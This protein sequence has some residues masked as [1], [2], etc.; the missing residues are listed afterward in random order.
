MKLKEAVERVNAQ[1][2]EAKSVLSEQGTRVHG[3]DHNDPAYLKQ[4]AW[5]NDLIE[6]VSH[7]KRLHVLKEAMTTDDFP[8]LFGDTIDRTLLAKYQAWLP[9]WRAWCRVGDVKDFRV[10]KRYAVSGGQDIL[11]QV[12]ERGPYN[13]RHIDE[14]AALSIHVDKY[15]GTFGLSWEAFLNDDLGALKDLPDRLS[16]GAR[17]TESLLVTNLYVDTNGPHASLYTGGNNNCIPGNPALSVS[18]LAAGIQCFADMVDADGHPI[19]IDGYTL[20]VP[21]ALEVTANNIANALQIEMEDTGGSATQKLIAK[22]WLAGRY[23]VEVDPYI[24]YVAAAHQ[25]TMWFLFAK[26]VGNR[27]A[28]EVAYLA[29]ESVPALFMKA[30]DQV[31]VGGGGSAFGDF[32]SDTVWYKCRHVIGG[33]QL[34]PR[35]TVASTGA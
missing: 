17:R 7:G 10:A 9:N 18:G 22:N 4:L 34:D 6:D 30:G 28:L 35:L 14:D 13:E 12:D 26:P 3:R 24:G 15:G 21:P 23:T 27:A 2:T 25:T 8:V 5:V 16:T 32:E 19:L 29:G 20:V 11:D 33:A 1:S 31:R